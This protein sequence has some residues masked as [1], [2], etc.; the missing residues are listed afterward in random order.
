M[1]AVAVTMKFLNIF[2]LKINRI[3]KTEEAVN[4]QLRWEFTQL[5]SISKLQLP[6]EWLLQDNDF[7]LIKFNSKLQ[8]LNNDLFA[9]MYLIRLIINI[10]KER[11][12]I[13]A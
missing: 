13:T 5:I 9:E 3:N 7:T 1:K 6:D 4:Y 8:K 10:H 12:C 2:F 11:T